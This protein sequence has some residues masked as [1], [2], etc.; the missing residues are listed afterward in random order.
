MLV[1]FDSVPSSLPLIPKEMLSII[2]TPEGQTR[3]R[4]N[5]SSLSL[6]QECWRKA[7]YSLIEKLKLNIES[8]A[9][10]FGSAIHKA[11][12]VFYEGSRKEREIP[13]E[14]E[15]IM[16]MIGSGV[17]EE[18]WGGSL[19]FRSARAFMVKAEALNHLPNDDKRSPQTGVWVLQNYFQTYKDDPYVVLRI[20]DK[21]LVEEKFTLPIFDTEELHI[22][23]FGQIDLV[24]KNEDTGVILPSDHKTSSRLDDSFYRRV[25]PNHQFTFYTW[26]CNDVLNLKT[27]AF[28]VNALEVKPPPKTSRGSPP[29][30][31]R[32]VTTRTRDD[33]DELKKVIITTVRTF[34]EL[35]EEGF[36][37]MTSPGPCANYSG[38]QYLSICEVPNSLKQNVIEAKYKKDNYGE[39]E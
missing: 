28:L 4:V 21:P 20:N 30:F 23:I 26:G 36:F 16:K 5:F 7:E 33:F 6:M 17:W 29:K 37:P 1:T 15:S 39:T 2:Q 10:L 13:S 34:L 38:C 25:K 8:P 19:I 18:S 35:K 14:F 27:D 24:L 9:T 22:E 3:V 12:E 11:L 31:L 32:Q